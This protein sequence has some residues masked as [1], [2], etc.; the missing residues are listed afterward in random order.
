MRILFYVNSSFGIGHYVRIGRIVRA[1]Q[2]RKGVTVDVIAAGVPFPPLKSITRSQPLW[3]PGLDLQGDVVSATFRGSTSEKLAIFE[4]RRL[5][6]REILSERAYDAVV[7]EYYPFSK[8]ELAKEVQ[9][10]VEAARRE[11]PRVAVY[12][13]VREIVHEGA[14]AWRGH[15]LDFMNW[16]G[17][18]LLVHG[19]EGFAPLSASFPAVSKLGITPR[20]TGFVTDPVRRNRARN[21]GPV[22][23]AA[24]G[25]RDGQLII[26]TAL[27][28]APTVP[29]LEV[30]LFPGPFLPPEA[31]AHIEG[32]AENLS[33]L[34]VGKFAEYRRALSSACLLICQAGY[35][36]T[37]EA[38]S[39]EIPLILLPRPRFEQEVRAS[40]LAE[41]GLA[42]VS[43]SPE[44]AVADVP[45]AISPRRE[46]AACSFSFHGTRATAE[47]LLSE[48]GRKE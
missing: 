5:R 34:R 46:R 7:I 27:L 10:L 42:T 17:A 32:T 29:D 1:L 21:R 43:N 8:Q 41:L 30:M 9:I 38:V 16:S 3:L 13:S 26:K 28:L 2:N 35:N 48:L 22:V 12:V 4:K 15:I 39:S 45:D 37:W 25:G 31:R 24:G 40:R 18:N 19:D 23:L 44:A 14:S 6:I 11:R 33:N 36:S 20:Y 47:L